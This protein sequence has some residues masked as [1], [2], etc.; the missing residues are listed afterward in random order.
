MRIAGQ[1]AAVVCL[2]AASLGWNVGQPC[3]WQDE[4]ATAV[5]AQR[6]LRY[7]KPIGYD[8]RNLITMDFDSPDETPASLARR[9][10]SAEAGVGYFVERG[11]FKEDTTWIGQPWGQFVLAA[12]SFQ[13]FGAGTWQARLPFVLCG[14]V[15]VVALFHF[16][17]RRFGCPTAW[18][19]V[20]LLLGNAYWILHVRQ[21]R[22]YAASSLLLLLTFILYWRWQEGRAWGRTAFVLA[23]WLLFQCDYGTF[24]PVAGVLLAES[25]LSARRRRS[26]SLLIACALLACVAP[27]MIYYELGSRLKTA[28]A[29]LWGRLVMLWVGTNQFVIP[30]LLLPGALIAAWF[31]RRPEAPGLTSCRRI[32]AVGIVLVTVVVLWMATVAPFPFLRYVIGLAPLGA[33]LSAYV[34]LAAAAEVAQSVRLPRGKYFFAASGAL[35]LILTPWACMPVSGL[36]PRRLQPAPLQLVGR[37]ELRRLWDGY[38]GATPDSTRELIAVLSPLL[39]PEDEILV[40]G[41][42]IPLVFYTGNRVRGGI[43]GFR[44]NDPRLAPPRF[45]VIRREVGGDAGRILQAYAARHKWRPL[46]VVIPDY[47]E[48]NCPDPWTNYRNR[49]RPFEKLSL[50]EIVAEPSSPL[51]Q[52]A[53]QSPSGWPDGLNRRPASD[54]LDPNN[55]HRVVPVITVGH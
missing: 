39:K 51:P 1:T 40:N 22:Y 19:T 5:L 49:R 30:L 2:A 15:A 7:G 46:P 12:A 9:T 16:V 18:L 35:L 54:H 44:I 41:E 8:G 20:L 50:A 3:L 26:E 21:C 31:D 24:V 38:R 36:V 11:D 10:S 42:D 33:W 53:F 47:P 45:L 37:D 28:A 52:A 29:P 43:P 55:L 23:S 14:L 27:W 32:V 17:R 34:V 6:M 4:A 25:L 48:A 13:L